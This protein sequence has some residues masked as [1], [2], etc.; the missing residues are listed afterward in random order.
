MEMG[1]HFYGFCGKF[2]KIAIESRHHLGSG[3]S[4]HQISAFYRIQHDVPSGEDE[5]TILTTYCSTTWSTSLN[6]IR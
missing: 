1:T 4:T 2:T 3:R 6:R 5:P